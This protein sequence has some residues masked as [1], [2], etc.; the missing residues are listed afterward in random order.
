MKRLIIPVILFI[1]LIFEGIAIDLLPASL[2]ISEFVFVPHWI[3]VFLV[4][5]VLFYDSDETFYGIIYAVIFGLLIDVVYTSVLG[6]YMII[7]PI[8][9]YAVGLMKRLLQTNWYM[10]IVMLIIGL[11]IVESAIVFIYSLV[12]MADP[13][14]SHFIIYRLLPTLA[15]NIFVLLLLYPIF[16]KRLAKWQQELLNN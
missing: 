5:V 13:F 3:F 1:L 14:S 8:G 12:N 15:A 11:S 6:V 2:I 10:A 16:Y 9:I 7:Y 4:L